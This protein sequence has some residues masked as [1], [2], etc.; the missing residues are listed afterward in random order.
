MNNIFVDGFTRLGK[1]YFIDNILSKDNPNLTII[2][3]N[4]SLDDLSKYYSTDLGFFNL[5]ILINRIHLSGS[6]EDSII[7]RS[8]IGDLSYYILVHILT[9][10]SN[11]D[12]KK[13]ELHDN[14][15]FELTLGRGDNRA[16]CLANELNKFFM[17]NYSDH[18][19][20]ASKVVALSP[21]F[22]FDESDKFY[23]FNSPQYDKEEYKKNLLS[24]KAVKHYK[25]LINRLCYPIPNKSKEKDEIYFGFCYFINYLFFR[26]YSS[27]MDEMNI[28]YIIK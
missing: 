20:Y 18:I 8:S 3:S 26:I 13:S 25:Y 2:Q 27:I 12:K 24:E 22:K 16:Y 5:M 14:I 4:H 6:T 15:D 10:F 1:D 21:I 28:D 17:E 9:Q 19:N 23:F 7:N 11:S